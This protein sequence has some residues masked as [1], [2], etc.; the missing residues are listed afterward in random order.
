MTRPNDAIDCPSC[1]S[2]GRHTYADASGNTSH[3]DCERCNG[4]GW[5]HRTV[6]RRVPLT[7]GMHLEAL[8]KAAAQHVMTP[9]E[10]HAQRR[11]WL[12]GEY[13]LA[14]PDATREDALK[15]IDEVLLKYS[16]SSHRWKGIHKLTEEMG[17]LAQVIGKTNV[18]P[19]GVHP[20][21]GPP[22]AQ[23]FSDELTDLEA[24]IEYFRT[25]NT[26]PRDIVRFD[27]KLAKFRKWGLTGVL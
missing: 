7:D 24:A 19:D 25:Q 23:R 12:L 13:L 10:E 14:H 11:S 6:P 16:T 17:E 3:D 15:L 18:F 21:G 9:Q 27:D 2:S 1:Q 26:I 8:L 4:R 22:L 20:D 5:I